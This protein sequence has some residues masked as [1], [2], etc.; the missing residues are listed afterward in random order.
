M[1]K[2][3]IA[4]S[5]RADWGLLHPLASALKAHPDVS[6]SILA[7]NMH[8]LERYGHTVDDIIADGFDVTERVD[9]PDTDDSEAGKVMAMAKCMEGT[10][11]ALSRISPDILVVL[12]DRYEC[13]PWPLPHAS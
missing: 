7:T 13:Y 10:A 8:L 12:G 3:C 5:T 1:L 11:L 9:M 4:T 6:L 2:I